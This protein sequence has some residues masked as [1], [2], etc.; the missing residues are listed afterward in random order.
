VVHNEDRFGIGDFGNPSTVYRMYRFDNRNKVSALLPNAARLRN[1]PIS[2]FENRLLLSNSSY[3][4]QR[5]ELH[6]DGFTFAS[7]FVSLVENVDRLRFSSDEAV[8]AIVSSS[9][10]IAVFDNI[11]GNRLYFPRSP[12]SKR[13]TEALFFGNDLNNFLTEWQSNPHCSR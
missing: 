10:N 12:L 4:L 5:A 8:Q 3:L 2:F 11:P 13:E 1:L 7:P 6:A 9:P